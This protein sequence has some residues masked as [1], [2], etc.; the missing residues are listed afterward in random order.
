MEASTDSQSVQVPTV[1]SIPKQ[2]APMGLVNGGGEGSESCPSKSRDAHCHLK[3]RKQ[4]RIGEMAQR[5]KSMLHQA[6]GP[7]LGSPV[8]T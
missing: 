2:P 5:V 8:S 3:E 7:E 1:A 4:N 6:G